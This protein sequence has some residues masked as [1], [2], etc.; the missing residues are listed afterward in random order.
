MTRSGD[1][2][3]DIRRM[4]TLAR[5]QLQSCGSARKAHLTRRMRLALDFDATDAERTEKAR[6]RAAQELHLANKAQ[7]L[8]A[9]DTLLTE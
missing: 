9:R 7:H 5:Q 6:R 4:V 8:A 2:L 3:S 1:S